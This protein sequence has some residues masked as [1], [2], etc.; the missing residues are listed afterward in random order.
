VVLPSLDV[1]PVIAEL[2]LGVVIGRG[3]RYISRE[4]A[5]EVVAGYTIFLDITAAEMMERDAAR[6]ERTTADVISGR[7]VKKVD[8]TPFFRCKDW[9]TF[10]QMGPA[11]VTKDEVMDPHALEIEGY[12][13]EDCFVKGKTS[14]MIFKIPQLIEFISSVLTLEPGTIIATGHPGHIH[15]RQLRPAEIVESHISSIGSMATSVLQEDKKGK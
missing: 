6:I 3:G 8:L 14:D 9:D 5:Y 13:G 11:L 15:R 7:T 10:G 12:V 4:N 1:G 2:E